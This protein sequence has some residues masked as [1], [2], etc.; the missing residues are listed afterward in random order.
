MIDYDEGDRG[1]WTL[2]EL[3]RMN[4]KLLNEVVSL[5]QKNEC[6]KHQ[7]KT[8]KDISALWKRCAKRKSRSIV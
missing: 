8:E 6:L 1:E 4:R 2:A 5:R 3:K 7:L